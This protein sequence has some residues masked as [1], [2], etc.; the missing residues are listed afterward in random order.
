AS[1]DL[2]WVLTFEELRETTDGGRTWTLLSNPL[3]DGWL[4][5]FKFLKDGKVGWVAGG[6]YSQLGEDEPTTN[7]FYAH[8]GTARG[9]FAAIFRTEDG[10]QT[11]VRQQVSRTAGDISGFYFLDQDHGWAFGEAGD[12]Y[13]KDG[14]WWKSESG[15]VDDR[16]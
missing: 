4:R 10:G 3:S 15:E 13:L 16:E 14:K 7:R 8:D 1:A 2:G 9:L 11:W 5:S 6:V 12:F